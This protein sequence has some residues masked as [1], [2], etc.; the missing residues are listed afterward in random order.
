VAKRRRERRRERNREIKREKR[1][2]EEPKT[3]AGGI[4]AFPF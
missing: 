2:E 4:P 1:K 3:V